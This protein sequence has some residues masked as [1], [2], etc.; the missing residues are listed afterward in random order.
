MTKEPS[1][2]HSSDQALTGN[3]AHS[4]GRRKMALT[5][6][7]LNAKLTVVVM[8]QHYAQSPS[9]PTSRDLSP[10]Q[11]LIRDNSESNENNHPQI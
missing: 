6:T 10:H 11:C 5:V 2:T 8:V 1:F 4:D 7:Q 9:P 3:A